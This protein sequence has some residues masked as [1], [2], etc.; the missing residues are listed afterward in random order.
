MRFVILL[1]L[2]A[3]A[4]LA[5]PPA[6]AQGTAAALAPQA[7]P[8]VAWLSAVKSG[9]ED[10]LKNAFSTMMRQQF[11]REG[12]PAVLS[13]YRD[14]FKQAFGDYGVEDFTLTF[15]GGDD[16]GRVAIGYKG[17]KLPSVLVVR[18]GSEWKLN[19]R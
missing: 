2:V 14:V 5:A 9:D 16:S 13:T 10:Q 6:S 15:S 8:V 7:R 1:P 17:A 12:W 3:I 11:E 4:V 18:E 19:E